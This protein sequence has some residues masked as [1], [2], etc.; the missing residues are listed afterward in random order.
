MDNTTNPKEEKPKT[1]RIKKYT[2]IAIWISFLLVVSMFINMN[3]SGGPEVSPDSPVTAQE[4]EDVKANFII[5]CK[6]SG[7]ADAYCACVANNIANS[8]TIE[9]RKRVSEF[10]D[11]TSLAEAYVRENLGGCV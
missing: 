3:S 11:N 10:G 5:G 9:T 6:S 7:G 2:W 1:S 8:Y 4:R